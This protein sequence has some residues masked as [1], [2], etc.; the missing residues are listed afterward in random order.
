M[1]WQREEAEQIDDDKSDKFSENLSAEHLERDTDRNQ[2]DE[3]TV[4]PVGEAMRVGPASQAD[5]RRNLTLSM[6]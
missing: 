2:E 6:P 1:E 3:E 5:Q 4:P